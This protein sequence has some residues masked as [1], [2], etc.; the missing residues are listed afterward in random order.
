LRNVNPD[1]EKTRLDGFD[2]SDKRGNIRAVEAEV[3][4]LIE[5]SSTIGWLSRGKVFGDGLPNIASA[6]LFFM[7]DDIRMNR[8]IELRRDDCSKIDILTICKGAVV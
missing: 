5:H 7:S 4:E 6:L 8:G 2:R 1:L 3:K